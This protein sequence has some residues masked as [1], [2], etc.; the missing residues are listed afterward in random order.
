M[1]KKM[2]VEL[3]IFFFVFISFC[4]INEDVGFIV[5][6]NLFQFVSSFNENFENDF[7]RI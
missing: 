2:F 4:S 3:Y 5:E 1:V 7:N 6:M